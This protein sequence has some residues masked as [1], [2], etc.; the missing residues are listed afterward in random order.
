MI[1]EHAGVRPRIDP[2][3]YVAPN[4]VVSGDVTVGAGA[5]VLFGAV[6]TAEGG[7]VEI[8]DRSIVMENA[9]IRGR[10]GHAARLGHDVLIGP[11]SHVNGAHIAEEVFVATGA[12]I[13]PGARIGRGS[14]IRIHAVV[15]VNAVLAP[16][17]TVPISWIAVGD[18]AVLFSPD[19]HD[20]LWEVQREADFPGTMFGVSREDATMTLIGSRYSELFGKHRDDRQV[21]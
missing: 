9:V 10:S 21:D 15:H 17:T 7:P 8:G 5:R 16:D 14:E 1:I 19:Q 18:P 6:V 12:A 13:F 11:H 2:S 20:A 4:A 3:A